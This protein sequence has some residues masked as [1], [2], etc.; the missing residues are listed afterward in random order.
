MYRIRKE[1]IEFCKF[2]TCTYSRSIVCEG[3]NL[4]NIVQTPTQKQVRKLNFT[5]FSLSLL[6]YLSLFYSNIPT[7]DQILFKPLQATGNL[8]TGVK[9]VNL[10]QTGF[11]LQYLQ[12]FTDHNAIWIMHNCKLYFERHIMSLCLWLDIPADHLR[13]T[14]TLCSTLRCKQE[15]A[16]L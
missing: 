4:C 1:S 3:I 10:N 2:F 14:S 12:I 11:T 7:D 16:A 9:S 13:T 5:H 6:T 15:D 8:F